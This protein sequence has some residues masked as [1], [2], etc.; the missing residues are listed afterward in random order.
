MQDTYKH[1]II[2]FKL[3]YI[4]IN[5]KRIFFRIRKYSKVYRYTPVKQRFLWKLKWH[6][7]HNHFPSTVNGGGTKGGGLQQKFNERIIPTELHRI[8]A[9]VAKSTYI[10]NTWIFSLLFGMSV[11]IPLIGKSMALLSKRLKRYFMMKMLSWFPILNIRLERIGSCCSV[12]AVQRKCWLF[13]IV[14]G[15]MII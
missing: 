10:S 15:K 6:W 1:V 8:F 13:R 9:F 14:I 4:I 7:P 2:W 3:C 12:S 11:R 5:Y